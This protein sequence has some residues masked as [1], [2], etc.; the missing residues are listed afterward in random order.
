MISCFEPN[1]NEDDIDRVTD[2]IKSKILAFG[3]S[4]IKFEKEYKKFSASQYNIGTNSASS[5]AYLIFQYLYEKYGSCR[6]YTPSLGFVSPVFAAIKNGHEVV[7]TDVDENLLM[8]HKSLQDTF[9]TDSRVSIIMPI[10]YGGVGNIVWLE[11]FCKINNCISIVDSAHCI[12]PVVSSDYFFYSFHP[13]KPVCM[14]NGGLIATNSTE[15]A[16]YMFRAR[17]FGRKIKGDTYDLVQSGFNF[18][19]NNL[20]ASLG[21]SQINKCLKNVEKRKN[22]FNFLKQNMPSNLGYLTAHDEYS[23]Y[24]LSTL[25]LKKQFS[26]AIMRQQLANNGVQASFHYPF[27]HT[28]DYYKQDISLPNLESLEDKIIN[29]PIHQELCQKD[30]EKIINECVRY[31]RSWCQP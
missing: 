31:S 13:V 27:L 21:L 17:N 16:E 30:L 20:N 24:Y 2:T 25:I 14:S 9:K 29:L 26:S 7:Y 5:A 3:P 12:S 15:A 28:S 8:C 23:S 18:Y 4:V 6:V 10:L 19:M 22:N 1:L 11:E